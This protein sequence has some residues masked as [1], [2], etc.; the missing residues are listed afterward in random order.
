MSSWGPKTLGTLL[1]PEEQAEA[2][3]RFVN[4]FTREHTPTW[5]TR[6]QPSGEPYPVQFASDAEWLS[7]TVFRTN[8]DG[9][10]HA[11]AD[12]NSYPTW[13]DNPELRETYGAGYAS[14]LLSYGT[15]PTS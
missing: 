13:P 7:N 14:R 10:L 3:A 6:P 12:C 15:E 9:A 4:R 1:R 8:T 5:A 11:T 2:L